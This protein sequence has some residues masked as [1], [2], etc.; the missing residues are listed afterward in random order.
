MVSLT[1]AFDLCICGIIIIFELYSPAEVLG[2]TVVLADGIVDERNL[3]WNS[4]YSYDVACV[5]P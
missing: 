2:Q 3:Y 1:K 4:F 5:F